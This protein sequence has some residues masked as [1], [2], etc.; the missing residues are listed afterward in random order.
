MVHARRRPSARSGRKRLAE[1]VPAQ[2]RPELG[3][4]HPERQ[5]VQI[6]NFLAVV[7]PKEYDAIQAAAQL[8]V[9]WKDDPKFPVGSGDYWSW[10]R[11]AGDTNTTN[12]ARWTADTG[13]VPAAMASAAKT[14][15]ATYQYHYNTYVPIGPHCASPTSAATS[16]DPTKTARRSSCPHRGRTRPRAWARVV[17]RRQRSARSSQRCRARSTS[18]RTRSG[19]SRSRAPAR[20][21]TA[22]ARRPP[23]R[24]RSI[25]ATIGKPVRV[26]WMRWDQT[27]WDSWG[28]SQMYDV[29]MGANSAGRSSLPTG[30]QYGQAG[31]FID[32]D[33]ELLGQ[34]TWPAT[35]GSGGPNPSDGGSTATPYGNTNY[36]SAYQFQRR[37][38]A[39]TQPLYGGS[40]KI[41][42]L[43][44]PNAPQSYFASE[45]IVD[46]LA[47]ARAS[48]RTH[49]GR[50]TSTERRRSGPAGFGS[51]TGRWQAS[52]QAAGRELGGSTAGTIR[53]GVGIGIGTFRRLEPVLHGGERRGEHEDRARWS[54]STPT[55]PK[56][57][58]SRSTSKASET[59]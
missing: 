54:Q 17:G 58:G 47:H 15:S 56:T 9:V 35:P 53:T 14:V 36:G 39:K 27:G 57:T 26:Q 29:T 59:K 3:R 28:P 41:T 50:R 2:R 40:L 7:A 12:P 33:L 24:P 20:T 19:W 13:G 51:S 18:R 31:S 11:K 30:R 42:A 48:I 23:R 21:A 1:P 45:Q 38:L 10:L 5:I 4:P 52:G 46:E 6:N 8:K 32:T 16:S 37:V 25:S 43:R 34:Q 55:S 49:S 22:R 44:A